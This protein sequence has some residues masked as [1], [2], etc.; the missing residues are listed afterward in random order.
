MRL[1]IPDS[2][3]RPDPEPT[4]TDART[5]L[6]VGSAAWLAALLAAL[7]WRDALIEQGLGWWIWCV[8]ISLVLGA[9]GL[10]WVQWR[11]GSD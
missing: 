6:L 1:W 10:A 7:L 8:V 11:R 4:R 9:L 2:E 5:A 3:R